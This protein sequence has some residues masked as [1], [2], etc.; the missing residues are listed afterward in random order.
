M[1]N[2][3]R[4]REVA[5]YAQHPELMPEEPI[6]GAKAYDLYIEGTMPHLLES[7]GELL[8]MGAGDSFFIGPA[9]ERWDRAMLVRQTSVESFIAFA[10]NE[11]Y[12]TD[13]VGHRT[14][15]LEDLGYFHLRS[16]GNGFPPMS[17]MGGMRKCDVQSPVQRRELGACPKP[18]ARTPPLPRPGQRGGNRACPSTIA[19]R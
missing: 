7:G 8:F 11:A 13:A 17:L 18:S 5:D 1:L 10:S 14:A 4:F 19:V 9:D 15:A 16:S 6:S 3:L 12:L 2:L